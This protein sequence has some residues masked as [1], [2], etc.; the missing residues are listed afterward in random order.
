MRSQSLPCGEQKVLT[1]RLAGSIETAFPFFM[2][3]HNLRKSR[4]GLPHTSLRPSRKVGDIAGVTD[5]LRPDTT[6]PYRHRSTSLG[7]SNDD[8]QLIEVADII[9]QKTAGSSSLRQQSTEPAAVTQADPSLVGHA[10]DLD[11]SLMPIGNGYPAA[12]GRRHGERP[13]YHDAG[14]SCPGAGQQGMSPLA[15]EMAVPRGLAGM[16]ATLMATPRCLR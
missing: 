8:V 12:R 10:D 2:I 3:V 11:T 15:L 5:E 7:S 9:A 6:I 13:G 16:P 4:I 14:V 1:D